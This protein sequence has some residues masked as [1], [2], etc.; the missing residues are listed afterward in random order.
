MRGKDDKS[1][2]YVV[3]D[4]VDLAH[5][6]A[7]FLGRHGFV[8]KAFSNPHALLAAYQSR[9]AACVIADVMMG[10]V[11][12]FTLAG[13]L[14][15]L[16]NSSAILFMTA[17]PSTS[18]AVDAVRRHQGID[19]LAKPLDEGRLLNSLEEGLR[20]SEQQRSA[21][22]R[23]AALT[24]RERQVFLLLIRGHSSKVIASKL[25]IS[26]RTVD[27]H[28]TRITLKTGAKS[29]AELIAINASATG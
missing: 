5:S 27:D 7:R 8:A 28:R 16:D 11:D 13:R 26:A 24:L 25:G 12:G 4:D 6:L 10:D 21:A 19:Y 17:W 3:D 23:L 29:I 1:L 14:R 2:I 18:A 20:W 9:P 15:A 22:S